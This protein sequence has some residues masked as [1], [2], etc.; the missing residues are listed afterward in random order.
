L[1]GSMSTTFLILVA[2]PVLFAL[3]IFLKNRNP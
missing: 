3:L 1:D 2:L